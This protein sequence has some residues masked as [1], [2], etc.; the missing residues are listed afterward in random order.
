MPNILGNIKGANG[1]A[2]ANGTNGAVGA[3]GAK[4]AEFLSG[5]GVPSNAL[6]VDGDSY[7]NITTGDLYKKIAGAW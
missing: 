5:A 7:L 6:G 1:A 4:G 2:G 3:T